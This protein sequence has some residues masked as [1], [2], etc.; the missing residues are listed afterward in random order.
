[1]TSD[2][3]ET[4]IGTLVDGNFSEPGILKVVRGGL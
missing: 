3:F 4:L 2:N 1:M